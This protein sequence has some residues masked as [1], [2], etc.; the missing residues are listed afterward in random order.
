MKIPKLKYP[1]SSKSLEWVSVRFLVSVR[2]VVSVRFMVSVR[3]LVGPRRE[4]QTGGPD[5]VLRVTGVPGE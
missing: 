5:A 3:F 4:D 2:F 1:G